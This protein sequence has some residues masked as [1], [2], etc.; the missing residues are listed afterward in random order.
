MNEIR[1][2]HESMLSEIT[3]KKAILIKGTEIMITSAVC[4]GEHVDFLKLKSILDAYQNVYDELKRDREYHE[5]QIELD[6][7]VEK[8]IMEKGGE[9]N[10]SESI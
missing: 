5:K 9:K 6:I 1:K 4:E 10:D 2:Y 7:E 8:N 3:I